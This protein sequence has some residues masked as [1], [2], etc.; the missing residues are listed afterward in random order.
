M[1]TEKRE[2]RLWETIEKLIFVK[3]QKVQPST[4]PYVFYEIAFHV[5]PKRESHICDPLKT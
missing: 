5:S 4:P 2:V 1:R 3:V